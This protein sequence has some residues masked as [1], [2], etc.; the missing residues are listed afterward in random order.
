MGESGPGLQPPVPLEEASSSPSASTLSCRGPAQLPGLTCPVRHPFSH[1]I[2]VPSLGT[3]RISANSVT[4][5]P[6]ETSQG[7][8]P[9]ATAHALPA[10]TPTT[11]LAD[12]RPGDTLSS[13]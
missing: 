2:C 1:V 9:P 10:S 3:G 6:R 5:P 8:S 7:Q 4:A 11:N 12:V 13:Q